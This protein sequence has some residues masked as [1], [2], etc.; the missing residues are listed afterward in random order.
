MLAQVSENV[1]DS[2][3]GRSLLIPKGRLI[4]AYQRAG[5]YGQQRVQ[6]R[7]AAAGSFRTLQ[8]WIFR[9]MPGTDQAG[10]AGFTDRVNNHYAATFATAALMSLISA[11]RDGRPNGRIRRGW[12]VYGAYGYYQPNQWAMAGEPA[13]SAAS[14][15][16]G[17]LGQQIIG[18]SLNRP[19]TI[20]IRPG[21]Q[22]NVTVTEDLAFPGP[23]KG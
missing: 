18:N 4:G 7:V 21:Y 19:P 5:A 9:K 8:A 1:F 23:Y 10:Y 13:G 2:A 6:N 20:E 15:Q 22:F 3:T 16:M 14:A 12:E 17:G 11:G